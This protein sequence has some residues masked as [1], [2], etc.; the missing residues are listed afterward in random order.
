MMDGCK[1]IELSDRGDSALPFAELA[2]VGPNEERE[3]L[4]SATEA[5][6]FEEKKGKKS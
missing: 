2:D 6:L 3:P 5:K 4:R 1:Q